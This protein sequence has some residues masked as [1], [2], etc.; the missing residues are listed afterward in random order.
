MKATCL[1]SPL[2]ACL[3]LTLTAHSQQL[4]PN[5]YVTACGTAQ[6]NFS[7]HK[8]KDTQVPLQPPPGKALVY[9]IETMERTPFISSN[10]NIGMD[11]AWLGATSSNSHMSFTVDPGL[12]HLCADYQGHAIDLEQLSNPLLHQLNAQAGHTYYLHYN[13]FLTRS[14]SIPYFTLADPD[15]GQ[16]L[17][18]QTQRAIFTLKK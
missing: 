3:A 15:E 16:F 11:G 5:P 9:I 8:A 1:F 6:A 13:L 12:H 17:V 10:V 18:Q 2:I 4:P 7:V 14:G